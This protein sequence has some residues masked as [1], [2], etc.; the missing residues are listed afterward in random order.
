[1]RVFEDCCQVSDSARTAFLNCAKTNQMKVRDLCRTSVEWLV[2]A[3]ILDSFEESGRFVSPT[4]ATGRFSIGRDHRLLAHYAMFRGNLYKDKSQWVRVH[5]LIELFTSSGRSRPTKREWKLSSPYGAFASVPPGELLAHLQS[6]FGDVGFSMRDRN[7]AAGLVT[8]RAEDV[9]TV[10]DLPEPYGK[11][12]QLEERRPRWDDQLSLMFEVRC[13]ISN[14]Q[15]RDSRHPLPYATVVDLEMS[16][17]AP[18]MVIETQSRLSR[19]PKLRGTDTVRREREL[20]QRLQE[21]ARD[22]FKIS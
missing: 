6:V 7:D 18:P 21:S 5:Q 9:C 22:W 17:L 11:W 20:N 19:I 12:F 16:A 1:M 10:M 4:G 13:T 8:F 15:A 3:S 2:T 14:I